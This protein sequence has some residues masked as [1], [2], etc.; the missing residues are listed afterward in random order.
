MT[1]LGS[2]VSIPLLRGLHLGVGTAIQ[3]AYMDS[4]QESKWCMQMKTTDI[5]E[6]HLY[7]L[8]NLLVL[9]PWMYVLVSKYTKPFSSLSKTLLHI[10]L[11]TAIHSA[12]YSCIHRLM[13]KCRYFRPIH[14][15]HHRYS[16][17]VTPS[18]A[19]AV[20]PLEFIFAYMLPFAVGTYVLNPTVTA[21]DTS[22]IIVSFF[23]LLVHDPMLHNVPW[24]IYF[25]PPCIHLKHHKDKSGNYSAPTLWWGDIQDALI[26]RTQ[27]LGRTIWRAQQWI[28]IKISRVRSHF[29]AF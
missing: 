21:L 9:G 23:N 19:N 29:K 12:L 6:A 22:V 2:G 26:F 13:H 8:F 7:S 3:G 14:R 4:M 10:P 24:P 11:L 28:R 18:V 27:R 16:T 1:V 25:V 17:N 20:S 15:F 5:H